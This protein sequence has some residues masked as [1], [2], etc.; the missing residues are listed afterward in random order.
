[1]KIKD[2]E[3]IKEGL[4][5]IP[6]K[7]TYNDFRSYY[8]AHKMYSTMFGD[9]IDD[10]GKNLGLRKKD[11]K[12][13]GVKGRERAFQKYVL[14]YEDGRDRTKFMKDLLRG[15]ILCKDR[16]HLKDTI[17][18]VIQEYNVD[19]KDTKIIEIK[20][21]WDP[22]TYKEN[23]D[24]VDVKIIFRHRFGELEVGKEVHSEL[25]FMTHDMFVFKHDQT[26]GKAGYG[27]MRQL[28]I[29]NAFEDLLDEMFEKMHKAAGVWRK[30]IK[31]NN[32]N[33]ERPGV[34]FFHTREP[35]HE[36]Q[37]LGKDQRRTKND[38]L[39]KYL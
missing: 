22:K 8:K 9:F 20:N 24:Y 39:Q 23:G 26:G 17:H 34:I 36:D 29:G 28:L 18:R 11:V 19:G 30:N 2:W 4:K 7:N 13:P 38:S 27:T 37:R 3:R 15:A 5:T 12:N 21:G 16:D 14:K 31:S 1:M 35:C 6:Y 10:L 25:Q 33:A 32:G